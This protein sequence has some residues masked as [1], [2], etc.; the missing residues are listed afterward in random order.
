MCPR[1]RRKDDSWNPTH[2]T[3]YGKA[4]VPAGPDGKRISLRLGGFK[5]ETDQNAYYDKAGDLLA[6]PDAGP[7]GHEARMEI[8]KMIR[9][10]HR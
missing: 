10:E 2:G 4:D 6:I 7:D 3:W 1:L 5:T 8:L 9:A